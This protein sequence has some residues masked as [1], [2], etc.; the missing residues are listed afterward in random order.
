MIREEKEL[1]Q[2][3]IR[4]VVVFREDLKDIEKTFSRLK[5]ESL[6]IYI[7]LDTLLDAD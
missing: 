5:N 1:V 3:L 7:K 6:E 2:N 4:Q